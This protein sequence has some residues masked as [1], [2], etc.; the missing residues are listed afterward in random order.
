MKSGHQPMAFVV[1]SDPLPHSAICNQARRLSNTL[2][3]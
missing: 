1:E 2:A 3:V